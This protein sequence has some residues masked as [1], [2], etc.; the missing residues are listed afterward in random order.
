MSTIKEDP[1]YLFYAG[2][3]FTVEWYVDEIGKMKAKEYYEALSED[4]QDRLDYIIRYFADSPIGTW[5]SKSL[6]TLEVAEHKIYA[7]KPKDH[8][9]FNFMTIGRKV[10]IVGAYRKHSQQMSKK[11]LNLL[12]AAVRARISYLH[13]V[14][15][16]TYY[17]GLA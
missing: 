5:L 12:K 10:V 8:R 6:Y 1:G 9:F 2:S 11:D 15:E 4:E 13:R 3:T 16:G 7:F 17:E 14:E